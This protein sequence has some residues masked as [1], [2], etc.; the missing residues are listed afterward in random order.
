MEKSIQR[1]GRKEGGLTRQ[2]VIAR[3]TAKDSVFCD[4]FQDKKYL[5]QLYQVL[6]PEDRETTEQDLTDITMRNVLTDGIYNDVG[7]RNRDKVILLAEAQATWSMNILIRMLLYLAE[8]YHSYFRRK[9]A[10][11]YSST[12]VSM[13]TA[14]LYVIFTGNRASKPESISLSEEFFQGKPCWRQSALV[15]TK[16]C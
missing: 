15:R 8:T 4:L 3:R 16:T 6:H 14:E 2:A 10:D 7:F 9:N 1:D 11:L 12:K 5:L 13:P